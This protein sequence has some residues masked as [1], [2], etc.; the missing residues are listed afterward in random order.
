MINVVVEGESDR[1]AITKL[2][3]S[4][5]LGCT[6][7]PRN[8]K[9]RLDP[10]IASYNR[11]AR[12]GPWLVVRDSDD[13][14]PVAL[15]A[16]LLSDPQSSAFSLRIAHTMIEAWLL[17]DTDG[18]AD[19]FSVSTARLPPRPEDLAHAKQSLI[20]L[21]LKSKSR[22]IRDDMVSASGERAGP[23]YTQRLN[24][25]AESTWDPDR[26]ALNAPSL[27]RA[28]REIDRLVAEGHWP[29]DQRTDG[30]A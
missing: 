1:G 9:T 2:L 21:C 18:F 16:R 10:Q 12:R 23:L 15:R 6:V 29:S 28:L 7:T 3:R 11:A 20:G 8:G 19:F 26:A 17:A 22:R 4:R 30:L 27:E 5:N 24:E 14:C 13:E 25:Y